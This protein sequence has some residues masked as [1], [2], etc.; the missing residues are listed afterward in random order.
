MSAATE[1]HLL[2]NPFTLA[3][4][5]LY[6]V[7]ETFEIDQRLVNVLQEGKKAVEVSIPTSLDNGDVRGFRGYR[8]THN[9]ARGRSKGGI[10]YPPDVTLHEVKSLA[11]WVT[12]KRAV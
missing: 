8:V 7:A 6:K 9:I 5:Q 2:E 1:T 10:R 12:W 11:M 4:Q 3:R